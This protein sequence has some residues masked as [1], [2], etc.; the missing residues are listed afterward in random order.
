MFL[1][2]SFGERGSGGNAVKLRGK[3]VVKNET[4]ILCLIKNMEVRMK[5]KGQHNKT[6]RA[7]TKQD[8]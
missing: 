8:M 6:D 3:M 2:L 5:K 4:S 7:T 1:P